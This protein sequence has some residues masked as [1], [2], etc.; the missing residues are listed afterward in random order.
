MK[1]LYEMYASLGVSREGYEFGQ[2]VLDSL[3]D[4][5]LRFVR[6]ARS[7]RYRLRCLFYERF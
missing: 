1:E 7:R 6:L 2:S 4:T 5:Q 3:K